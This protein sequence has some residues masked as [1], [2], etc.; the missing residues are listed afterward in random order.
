[1]CL[2][3]SGKHRGLGVHISFVRSVTMDSWSEIQLKKMESGGNDQLNQF[4]ARY[5]VPKETDIVAKYNTNAASVYRER[6]Q[7]LAEGQRWRD[8]PVVKEGLGGGG[9]ANKNKKPPLSGGRNGNVRFVN[10]ILPDG[11]IYLHI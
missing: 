9:A 8:P 5:G 6:I 3:C 2:E 1:M 10:F 7:A 4:L 11:Y